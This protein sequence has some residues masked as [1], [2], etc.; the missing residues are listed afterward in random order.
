MISA[1]HCEF[2]P[3]PNPDLQL[4][5]IHKHNSVPAVLLCPSK[6]LDAS[7]GVRLRVDAVSHRNSPSW[8]ARCF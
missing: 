8:F 4:C 3:N 6:F 1:S 7:C 2:P 5:V